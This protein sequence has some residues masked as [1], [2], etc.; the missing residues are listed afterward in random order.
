[1]CACVLHLLLFLWL[2]LTNTGGYMILAISRASFQEAVLADTL[3]LRAHSS[4]WKT[5]FG[6]GMFRFISGSYI[7]SSATFQLLMAYLTRA[8]PMLSKGGVMWDRDK[9]HT[10]SVP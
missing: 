5:F 2:T 4:K 9:S 10:N 3:K 1:M 7:L 6:W 8:D